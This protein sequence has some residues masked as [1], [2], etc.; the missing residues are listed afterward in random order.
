MVRILLAFSGSITYLIRPSFR[1]FSSVSIP[2]GIVLKL[3]Y[4]NFVRLFRKYRLYY[5]SSVNIPSTIYIS[6]SSIDAC[7]LFFP[8]NSSNSLFLLILLASPFLS[9]FD[10]FVLHREVQD[11]PQSCNHLTSG[12][13]ADLYI[14]IVN[15]Q[16]L[17]VYISI[18]IKHVSAFLMFLNTHKN[19]PYFIFVS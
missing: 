8:I 7:F 3:W 2:K 19:V 14:F 6:S 17:L 18:R 13:T 15:R 10:E 16:K 11:L 12:R 5:P 4:L 9:S 1:W